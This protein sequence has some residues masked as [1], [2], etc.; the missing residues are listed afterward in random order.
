M[1]NITYCFLIKS[2]YSPTETQVAKT[3]ETYPPES[4]SLPLRLPQKHR[5]LRPLRLLIVRCHFVEDFPQKHRSLRPLRRGADTGGI[6]CILI[7]T[8]TQVA[9][10]VETLNS[11]ELFR[12]FIEPTETQVAKTVETLMRE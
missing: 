3:V 2:R 6:S 12:Q 4:S 9:K 7:P 8:E 5:S 1:G 10:T 11:G